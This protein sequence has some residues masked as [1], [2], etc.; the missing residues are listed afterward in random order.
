MI[1]Y[2][3]SDEYIFLLDSFF[4]VAHRSK[5]IWNGGGERYF[6]K[7]YSRNDFLN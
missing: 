1:Q 7:F 2:L 6:H 4:P 5:N 3:I